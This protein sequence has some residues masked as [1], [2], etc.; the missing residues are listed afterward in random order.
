MSYMC[1]LC[2][3]LLSVSARCPDCGNQTCEDEGRL[4]DFYGPYSPYRPID[5]IRMSNGWMDVS[6]HICLHLVRC[7]SCGTRF[8]TCVHEWPN[9]EAD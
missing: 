3:G 4:G 8:Q 2:N 7:L 9:Q 5:D 6:Q 1:P